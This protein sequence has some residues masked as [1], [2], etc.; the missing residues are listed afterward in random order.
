MLATGQALEELSTLDRW[1]R[2]AKHGG[3]VSPDYFRK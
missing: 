3:V 2:T 1:R